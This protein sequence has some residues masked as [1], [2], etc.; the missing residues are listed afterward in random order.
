MPANPNV[1]TSCPPG[2]QWDAWKGMC[3]SLSPIADAIQDLGWR[4]VVISVRD[5]R[6]EINDPRDIVTA[7]LTAEEGMFL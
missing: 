6:M 5:E 7:G 2:Q 1:N 4:R 3:V